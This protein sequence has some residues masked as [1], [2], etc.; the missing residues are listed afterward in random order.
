M[1]VVNI[2]IFIFSA[3]FSFHQEQI[4]TFKKKGCKVKLVVNNHN[5]TDFYLPRICHKY[6]EF[7][8]SMY[9]VVQ[10]TLFLTLE[11]ISVNAQMGSG[12]NHVSHKVDGFK[13][14]IP[15]QDKRK[16]TLK[17]NKV[18]KKKKIRALVIKYGEYSLVSKSAK[19]V[20]KTRKSAQ[21]T[22]FP[23]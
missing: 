5:N 10:D 7:P 15:A 19:G 16:F 8:E 21:R 6:D 22:S 23:H 20:N 1:M 17:L 11:D 9:Y 18:Y 14:I 2:L 3:L 12:D 4:L 13:C